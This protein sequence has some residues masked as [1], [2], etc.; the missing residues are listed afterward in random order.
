HAAGRVDFFLGEPHAEL[1]VGAERAEKAGQRRE[2]A[3]LDF[4]GLAI[5]DRRKPQRRGTGKGGAGFQQGS[6]AGVGHRWSPPKGLSAMSPFNS[7]SC[8]NVRDDFLLP[9][10]ISGR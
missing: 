4:L 1:G 2:V 3:D 7:G 10:D 5:T 9:E 8:E 6:S